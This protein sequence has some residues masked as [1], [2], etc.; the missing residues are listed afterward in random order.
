M[1]E[2]LIWI[3][4]RR[5]WLARNAKGFW[6]HWK[7]IVDAESNFGDHV[8]LH[9]NSAV[10]KSKI[11]KCTYLA[12]E[13]VVN[14]SEVG[15]FCSIGPQTIIGGLGS[16]PTN[17]LST[18]PAF[19]SCDHQSG[20]I[21]TETNIF[22]EYKP[23]HVGNDVWIGTRAVVLDG[24]RVGDGAIVAAGAVVTKDVPPYSIVGGVPARIIRYRFS[25]DVIEALLNWRWWELPIDTLKGISPNIVNITEWSVLEVDRIRNE[26]QKHSVP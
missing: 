9:K 8:K 24:V 18:H 12:N 14:F 3:F 21:F 26:A 19:Y 15:A 23:T 2:R 7:T 22:D 11:G 5:W 17:W 20:V 13:S 1:L 10:I 16:H 4:Y 6:A 25:R